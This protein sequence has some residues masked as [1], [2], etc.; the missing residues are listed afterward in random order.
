MANIAPIDTTQP[1]A[2][3]EI[4]SV[5]REKHGTVP[6]IFATMAHSPAVVESYLAVSGA[7]GKGTLSAQ[8]RE[9][10]A[11]T[12]AGVNKCDYCASA[13][14]F[15]AV[16]LGVVETEAANNLVGRS[17]DPR[18]AAILRFAGDVVRDRGKFSHNASILNE[19]RSA[20]VSD[21]EIVEIIANVSLN[22]FTNYFNHIAGTN[23]DFPFVNS[24]LYRPAAPSR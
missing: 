17:N 15:I 4:L 14:T 13:H 10:I 16:S 23:I 22:I 24:K 8:V 18:T 11:L 2:A 3:A 9:Q 20:G 12:V 7:L 6:N 5:V 1:G 19:L 21:A